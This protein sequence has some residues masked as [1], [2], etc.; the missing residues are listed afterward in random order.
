MEIRTDYGKRTSQSHRAAHESVQGTTA[1]KKKVI[2]TQLNE[3][4]HALST[5]SSV[6]S[7]PTE[8]HP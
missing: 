5:D 6:D 2:N 1:R 8:P 7:G 3:N 4:V